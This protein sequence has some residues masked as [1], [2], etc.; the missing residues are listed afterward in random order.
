MLGVL[1]AL[2]TF[3]F[4]GFDFDFDYHFAF[5]LLAYVLSSTILICRIVLHESACSGG[6]L[7]Y[8]AFLC[9]LGSEAQ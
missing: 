3:Y 9:P 5:W 2:D 6:S 7:N 4:P 1:C 8:I